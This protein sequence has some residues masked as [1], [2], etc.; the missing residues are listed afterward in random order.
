MKSR[1]LSIAFSVIALAC[2]GSVASAHGRAVAKSQRARTNG[3]ILK[4]YL[5]PAT[6]ADIDKFRDRTGFVSNQEILAYARGGALGTIYGNHET[7][8]LHVQNGPLSL[9]IGED[10][11]L[12]T[13]DDITRFRT[14]TGF[15]TNEDLI[16]YGRGGLLR[17]PKLFSVAA[18][19]LD[20]RPYRLLQREG[21]ALYVGPHAVK[22]E[23]GLATES[24]LDEFRAGTG[25]TSNTDLLATAQAGKLAPAFLPSI[26]R[27]I[28]NL[29]STLYFTPTQV[30]TE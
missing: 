23:E 10:A 7:H 17:G 1:L 27:R 2:V 16:A 30:M 6:E 3:T 19:H 13:E 5:R 25:F 18:V 8:F 28:R 20:D 15:K 22:F 26:T 14:G 4:R 24:D 11:R 12:A 21:M 29:N 9:L